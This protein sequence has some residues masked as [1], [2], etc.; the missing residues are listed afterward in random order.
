M[1]QISI[2]EAKAGFAE[3]VARAEA[4]E[5][6]VTTRHGEPVA[7]VCA[8]PR[9]LAIPYGDLAGSGIELDDDMTL[10]EEVVADFGG[11]GALR[12]AAYSHSCPAMARA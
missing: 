10:P 7:L 8:L 5:R 11:S 4:G 2:A 9:A 1:A 3:L 6:I 12:Y